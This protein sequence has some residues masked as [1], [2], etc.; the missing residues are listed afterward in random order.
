M[1]RGV[2]RGPLSVS[3]GVVAIA[4]VFA[5]GTGTRP[6]RRRSRHSLSAKFGDELQRNIRPADQA[7]ADIKRDE[8][9]C[10]CY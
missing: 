7:A 5:E 6:G 4:G 2:L 9:F 10:Q 3:P 1:P 8:C